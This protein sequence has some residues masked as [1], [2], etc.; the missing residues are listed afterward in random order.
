[1]IPPT[2]SKALYWPNDLFVYIFR[3]AFHEFINNEDVR[4]LYVYIHPPRQIIASL[5]PPM[6]L[7][8]KSIFFLKNNVGVKL[9]KENMGKYSQTMTGNERPIAYSLNQQ[10][11]G[12]FLPFSKKYQICRVDW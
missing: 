5:Q 9:T 7:C 1:M 4:R 6:L 11:S 8:S 2:D 12:N 10:E 3:L